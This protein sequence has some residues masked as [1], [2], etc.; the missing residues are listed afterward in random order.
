MGV[1]IPNEKLDEKLDE[2]L[3]EELAKEFAQVLDQDFNVRLH[4][5]SYDELVEQ[6]AE[7]Q[8]YEWKCE[9]CDQ[10]LVE[11]RQFDWKYAQQLA[12]TLNDKLGLEFDRTLVQKLA[13]VLTNILDGKLDGR[14]VVSK[15][16]RL[17]KQ[18]A[19]IYT[20]AFL[21]ARNPGRKPLAEEITSL[22][23]QLMSQY[24]VLGETIHRS[25]QFLL[26][27]AKLGSWV[28]RHPVSNS[29][30]RKSFQFLRIS[31]TLRVSRI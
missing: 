11:I 2:K 3:A 12:E 17:W 18:A 9:L 28:F 27:T 21:D 22:V 24:D 13:V 23:D 16:S 31:R 29:L 26:L 1:D 8:R 25:F 4:V 30:P 20:T 19:Q 5:E 6:L 15:I 7:I 10:Q 14:L